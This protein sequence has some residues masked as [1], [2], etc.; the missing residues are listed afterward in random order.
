MPLPHF[1]FSP[2][3]S[4]MRYLQSVRRFRC[5]RPGRGCFCFPCIFFSV[6]CSPTRLIFEIICSLS[7]VFTVL[8]SVTIVL[9]CTVWITSLYL[10][11]VY[12]DVS[13]SIFALATSFGTHGRISASLGQRGIPISVQCTLS[14]HSYHLDRA[15]FTL[16]HRRWQGVIDD[17]KCS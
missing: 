8:L 7:A 4:A 11:C 3:P 5:S 2:V 13:I 17:S 1:D 12:S 9:L 10:H 6:D 16:H 15:R 14:C